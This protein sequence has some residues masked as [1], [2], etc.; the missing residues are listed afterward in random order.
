MNAKQATEPGDEV[1]AT[2][3]GLVDE[4]VADADDLEA[5]I[6]A[7]IDA[8]PEYISAGEASGCSSEPLTRCWAGSTD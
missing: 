6:L 2:I 4:A 5:E 8:L 3:Q 1:V 7:E